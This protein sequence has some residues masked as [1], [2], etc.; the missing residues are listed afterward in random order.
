MLV[1]S[2][3]RSV[4]WSG[5]GQAIQRLPHGTL[6][7]AA[8]A[9][10]IVHLIYSTYDLIG[11]AYVGHRLTVPRTM[12]ITFVSYAFNLNFGS[13]VGGIAFRYRLYSRFGV[14]TPEVTRILMLSLATNWLGYLLLAGVVFASRLVEI[15]PHWRLGPAALQSVGVGLLILV[16]V[17]IGLCGWSRHRTVRV[18]DHA[19][20]LPRLPVAALQLVASCTSWLTIA[21]MIF[22]LL[23][24]ASPAHVSF[25]TVLG[26][27][28]I[29]AVAGVLTHV[30]AALGVL[31]A[32]FITLL[33][34][35][36]AH[37]DVLAALF[38]YRAVY[39]LAPLGFAI[40]VYVF[41][42]TRA[43]AKQG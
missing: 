21:A 4:D 29:S 43:H 18:R 33:G 27:L 40:V 15:P 34:Q 16:A 14:T 35:H 22:V 5:V 12:A 37:A 28:L 1:A 7:L 9:A 42:E 17:Y 24:G 32:V 10:V 41:L 6:A 39:Y 38:A 23:N 2:H 31:E 25:P 3:A 13:L 30:P 26:V 20:E 19:F 36:I 11:R 8:S